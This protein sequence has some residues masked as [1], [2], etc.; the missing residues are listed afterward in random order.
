MN[1]PDQFRV[2][3]FIRDMDARY[4]KPNRPLP[5]FIFIH[6][7]QDHTA[8][9]RAADGY[10]TRAAYVADNDLALG[11]IV[12]YL[13]HTQGGRNMAIFVTEDDAGGG[14][15]QVDAHR[16]VMLMASPYAKPGCV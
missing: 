7:P 5:R 9:P 16:T 10:P 2:A 1:I 6:L 15:D 12:A 14:V 11:K 4:V 3:N 13:S 8:D